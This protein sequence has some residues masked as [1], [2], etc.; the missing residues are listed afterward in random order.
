LAD[1]HVDLETLWGRAAIE[2]REQLCTALT[3]EQRFRILGQALLRHLFRP[4]QHHYAVSTALQA[5]T[6]EKGSSTVGDLTR[7]IGIS[8]RR[9]IR[10]FAEEVGSTPKVFGR[11][12]RFHR[13]LAL[14]HQSSAINWAQL[15][16]DTGYFDQSHL[17]RDFLEFSGVS[18]TDYALRL[19][20]V[21][22]Q[23]VHVKRNHLPLSD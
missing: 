9:L 23:G 5:L 12:Q 3:P 4:L 6:L 14:V 10:V 11:I 2:L 7:Q 22:R 21:R 15:A 18:P 16:L 17:I 20:R 19:D 13:A 1:V 8:Q